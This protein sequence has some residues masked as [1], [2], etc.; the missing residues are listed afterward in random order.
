MNY[1]RRFIV[2]LTFV[3]LSVAPVIR[4]ENF[5]NQS[6]ANSSAATSAVPRQAGQTAGVDSVSQT[7]V[8]L[9]KSV[10]EAVESFVKIRI[11]GYIKLD[12]AYDSQR[13]QTGDIIY[14][15]FPKNNGVSDNE[16]NMTAKETRLGLELKAPEID[17]IK[18]SGKVE[19]DFYGPS[20]TANSPNLRMRLGYLDVSDDAIGALRAGQDWDT[21]ITVLPRMANISLLADAGALGIRRPQLR[22]SRDLKIKEDTKLV[23]KV[24][25]ARTIGADLDNGGQED[26]VD[27]GFPSAQYNLCLET[28]LLT[29][30]ATKVSVS[31]HWGMETLDVVSTN[32]GVVESDKS[33]YKSYSVIGSL[34]FPVMNWFSLQGTIWQGQDLTS[35]YGGIGQGINTKLDTAI[36][37]QG[38]WAQL[39]FDITKRLNWNMGYGFDA[40]SNGDL[41]ANN[42]S[43]NAT[44]FTSLF[45]TIKPLTFAVEYFNMTTSYKDASAATDNRVQGSLILTF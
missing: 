9:P 32:G 41:N 18:I 22:L 15:V 23:A 39:V 28:K 29:E 44:L 45:Y 25:V 27:A 37:A 33:W 35:Y 30:K 4:A 36:A 10:T 40:P 7:T 26:G 38:G 13:V 1:C 2:V 3:S 11:Y 14:Y 6:Q 42:R 19:V 31:G 34:V 43:R 20:G 8:P 24:A 21:F 12:A 5:T 16:F 17:S